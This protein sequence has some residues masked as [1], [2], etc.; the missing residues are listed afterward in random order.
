[1]N[2][3]TGTTEP[4]TVAEPV[5]ESP[6]APKVDA[7]FDPAML[8]TEPT[9]PVS[10]LVLTLNE[11]I[12]IADC[13]ASC[14]WCDDVHVLDS[15]S[16]D[17]TVEIAEAFGAHVH[18]HP[19]ESFGQQRNWAIDHIPMAHDWVFHLDA[20]ER[21][22]PE[23]VEAIRELLASDPPE[24]GFHIPQKLMFMGRWL[25]RTAGYPTYQMR[26]FHK[27]RMRFRDYGHGQREQTEGMVGML[28]VPYL[29]FSFSK[30]LYDWLDKHNRYSS[31]EAL[32]FVNGQ[33]SWSFS[34][35][36][37]GDRVER[38]R[39]WKVFSYH[40]PFRASLRW[41]AILFLM[42]GITE[43]R[44]GWNYAR[45]I[46]IYENMITLK[47]RLLRS[48]R[49]YRRPDF[50]QDGRPLAR[51]ALTDPLG[52]THTQVRVIDRAEVDA[53]SGTVTLTP[54]NFIHERLRELVRPDE[55][56]LITGGS[57]FI[58]TNLVELHRGCG[59]EMVNL[60]IAPPR[61]PAHRELWQRVD[62]LEPTGLER[63]IRD[64]DPHVVFHLAARADLDERAGMRGYAANIEG[65]TNILKAVESL[66]QI[67]RMVVT[68]TQL[69]CRPG[70]TPRNETDYMPHTI[71]GR[72]K[73]ETERIT[74][75]WKNPPCPWV[76]VRPTSMWGPWFDI[77]YRDFFMTVSKNRYMHQRGR[78]P[79]RS[80]GFVGNAVFQYASYAEVDADK[81]NGK[82]F[83]MSDYEPVH[84]RE[85]AN[86]I[87]REMGVK[88]LREISVNTLKV[89]AKL[90]DVAQSLGWKKAPITSFRLRNLLQ[91]NYA[92]MEPVR[93]AMGPEPYRIR[94]GVKVTVQW[95][96][97]E[98]LIPPVTPE[99]E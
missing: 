64:F 35:M 39:A 49:P 47:I 9:A 2:Q 30:G 96:R 60:D 48:R 58:G 52:E 69:V 15:H 7:S 82:T 45:L 67:R 8:V 26:L 11:E 77:P 22:T 59:A 34:Q 18:R 93:E 97:E 40:L 6:E 14:R 57:G 78:D 21:F 80:F 25:K 61:N 4:A 27:T 95:M 94:E 12:N 44:A 38:W 92:D 63:V 88:P 81:I 43:G 62:L 90:G 24:S 46:R 71:Y 66:K 84:V 10:V 55:R 89:A 53:E 54:D 3:T 76:L 51:T 13:L 98:G 50:E 83:Y 74:R 70:Y 99:I 65:V 75:A 32:Q 73:I 68:S 33:Q 23:L 85:W 16:E 41:L 31:L 20:D 1:M 37:R 91:D 87:Q 19:F 28:D 36:F 29:H 5:I 56:V 42:G 86:L 79:L 17:R 72:S